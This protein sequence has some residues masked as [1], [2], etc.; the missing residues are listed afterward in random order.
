MWVPLEATSEN[1]IET[2]GRWSSRLL[3]VGKM[4]SPSP[5]FPSPKEDLS[6]LYCRLVGDISSAIR[7]FLCPDALFDQKSNHISFF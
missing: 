1:F 4:F 2:G 5:I 7:D 6:F 3:L